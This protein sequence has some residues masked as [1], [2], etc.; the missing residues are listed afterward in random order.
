M[1]YWVGIALM[2]VDGLVLT[3]MVGALFVGDE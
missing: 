2:A 1:I 3:I